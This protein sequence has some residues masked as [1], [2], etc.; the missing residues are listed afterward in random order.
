MNLSRRQLLGSAAAAAI[1]PTIPVVPAALAAPPAAPLTF[2]TIPS[3]L[4]IP[5]FYVEDGLATVQEV[6]DAE[7]L[8]ISNWVNSLEAELD[9]RVTRIMIATPPST[10]MDGK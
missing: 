3:A 5:W 6:R 1:V 2:S 4:R 10:R 8:S 9:A 7:G